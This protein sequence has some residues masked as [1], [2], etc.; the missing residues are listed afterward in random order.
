[1]RFKLKGFLVIGLMVI[2]SLASC[3]SIAPVD[4]QS[5]IQE[6]VT[7]YISARQN[8]D[9]V[10]MQA[11]Y[12]NPGNVRIGNIR[13]LESKVT[14]ID[15]SEDQ[16]KAV[17]KLENKMQVMGFTF[18]KTP[19]TIHWVWHENEWYLDVD[20]PGKSP[21]SQGDRKRVEDVNQLKQ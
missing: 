11:Y 18:D 12:V 7:G 1:M 16:R 15:I 9:I 3:R 20:A 2:F 19:Q 8:S 6:R 14:A 13:Y 17:S 21:F 5:R 4:P 10:G